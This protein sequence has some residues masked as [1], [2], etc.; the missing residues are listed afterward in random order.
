MSRNILVTGVSRGLGLAIAQAILAEGWTVFGVSRTCSAELEELMRQYGDRCRIQRLDLGAVDRIG[1]VVFEQLI[2]PGTAVHGL[3]NNAALAY[4]DLVTNLDLVRLRAMY[5]V[6]VFA[7]ML[8]TKFAIRRML[9]EQTRGSIVHVSSVSAHT[10]YKGLAMYASTKGALEAFSLN[11]AREWGER[12]IRSNCV[13]AGFMETEMSAKLSA[14]QRES[15]VRR[16]GLK[17]L[18]PPASVAATVV[19][20]LGEGASAVTGEVIRVDSGVL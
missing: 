3:V 17:Q 10:G 20:L 16:T 8:L 1:D 19:Y 13:A 2:P 14:E 4:D 12:G 11:T 6:N 18:T 5:D 7:P 9:V 15:I